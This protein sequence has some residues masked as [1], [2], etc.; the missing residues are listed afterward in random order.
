MTCILFA[1]LSTAT[2]TG[3]LFP[4]PSRHLLMCTHRNEHLFCNL[5]CVVVMV[6]VVVVVVYIQCKLQNTIVM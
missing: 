1:A 3:G 5:H 4:L 6:V 2:C